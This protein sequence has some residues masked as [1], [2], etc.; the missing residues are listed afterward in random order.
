MTITPAGRDDVPD[1]PLVAGV[2]TDDYDGR[3]D[4]G[5]SG[6]HGLDLPGSMR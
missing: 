4:V 3:T 1:E 5:A 2:V 6:Q